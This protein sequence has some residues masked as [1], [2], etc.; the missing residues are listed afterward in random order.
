MRQIK[1]IFTAGNPGIVDVNGFF[2]VWNG[3][4]NQ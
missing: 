2:N 1:I 3:L 4:K